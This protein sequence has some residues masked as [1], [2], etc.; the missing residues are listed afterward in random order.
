MIVISMV[1]HLSTSNFNFKLQKMHLLEG[2]DNILNHEQIL[3]LKKEVTNT[4]DNNRWKIPEL[5]KWV[6]TTINK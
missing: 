4:P 5:K 2:L 3:H 6:K 1:T